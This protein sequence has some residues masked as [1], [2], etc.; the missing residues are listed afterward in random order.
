G[1]WR[2]DESEFEP[3]PARGIVARYQLLAPALI[4]GLLLTFFPSSSLARYQLLT[5]A[6][7]SGLLLTFF[8]Q[9]PQHV[10]APKV[11]RTD[12]K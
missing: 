5:P 6:L 8:I 4:S 12:E 3:A 2:Q 11:Y 1:S 7:T 10:N 9:S